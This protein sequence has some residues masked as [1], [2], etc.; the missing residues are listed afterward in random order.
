MTGALSMGNNRIT[1]FDDPTNPQRCGYK[2]L[3]RT[4]GNSKFVVTGGTLPTTTNTDTVIY[5]LPN[6]K[7]VA[8]EK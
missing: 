8:N 2:I 7:T 5:T 4:A 6:E 3:H 1:D